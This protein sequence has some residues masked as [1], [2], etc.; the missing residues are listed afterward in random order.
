MLIIFLKQALRSFTFAIVCFVWVDV[1]AFEIIDSRLFSLFFL[2]CIDFV[3]CFAGV[4]IK[5]SVVVVVGKNQTQ[6]DVQRRNS[7]TYARPL[8]LL[9]DQIYQKRRYYSLHI[10]MVFFFIPFLIVI[11]VLLQPFKPTV[12]SYDS[13]ASTGDPCSRN[14]GGVTFPT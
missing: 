12:V 2:A 3:L 1:L 9:V 10:H 14:R 6:S 11:L 5:Y 7:Q 8:P 13:E 4:K